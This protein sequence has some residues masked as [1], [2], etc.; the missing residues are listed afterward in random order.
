MA[1]LL[2]ALLAGVAA[3]YPEGHFDRAHKMTT[4]NFD[5]IV[6]TEVDAG[7]TLFVRWVASAG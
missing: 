1:A 4:A 6:Q 3:I 5:E 7:K 2:L